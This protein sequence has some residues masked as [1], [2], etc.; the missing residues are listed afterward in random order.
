MLRPLHSRLLAPGS[1]P[2][3]NQSISNRHRPFLC[4]IE[5]AKSVGRMSRPVILVSLDWIRPGDPRT[6]LGTASIASALKSVGIDCLV[7]SDAVNREGF[8]L[9]SFEQKIQRGI[10]DM[11]ATTLVGVGAYVWAENEVK[12][13]LSKLR[14]RVEVAVGGPQ[15]SYTGAGE[16]EEFYPG[17]EYF[18]R[19]HGEAAMTSLGLGTAENGSYGIH[20]AGREDLCHRADFSLADLPSP[21]LDGTLPIGSFV[22]WETQ[23][24]CPY[25]CSFCQHKEAGRSL[26]HH[27]FS[28]DRL[29]EEV[30]RFRVA[31]VK[32]IAVLDP[33]FNT[34]RGRAVDLLRMIQDNGLSAA[35]SLQCRFELVDDAFLEACEGLDVTLEFGLQT[36]NSEEGK[37][38]GRRNNVDKAEEVIRKL[39]DREISFEVSLIYGLPLQTLESFEES[40]RWCLERDIPRVRAWPLMLLRGTPLY[41]Q[42]EKWSYVESAT[43]RIPHVIASNS[44][45]REEFVRMT[46]IATSLNSN[47]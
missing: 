24:G 13:L 43:E 44:F 21:H 12:H 36:T 40:V 10:D 4:R 25:G 7:V 17:V 1:R 18:V 26:K 16:L 2:R 22:R 30:R 42:R 14:R 20:I 35:L 9:A 32:R 19:G 39:H 47:S 38:V 8:D 31:G 27:C 41:Q 37:A 23:R 11:G 28:M 33:I 45:S 3:S 15:V 34:Q 46:E 6:G 5:P 29:V